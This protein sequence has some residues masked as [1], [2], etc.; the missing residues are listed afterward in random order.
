MKRFFIVLLLSVM[1]CFCDRTLRLDD[2]TIAIVGNHVITFDAYK[3]RYLDFLYL[4]L[5]KDN[6]VTRRQIAQNM[7]NEILLK[8]YDDNSALESNAPYQ[9]DRL[10]SANQMLL[11]FLKDQEV[12]AKIEVGEA[13]IR[14]AFQYSNEQIAA[15]HLYAT[16]EEEALRLYNALQEGADFEQLAYDVFTDSTL[17]NN[18]G[19]IGY[20]SWGDM[21]PSFEETAFGLAVGEISKPV[22]TARGYS[23]IKLEDRIPHPLLTETE[24]QNKRSHFERL[25]RISRKKKY[26][27]Q[28]LAR[29]FDEKNLIFFDT[30][31]DVLWEY[32]RPMGQ[33]SEKLADM[34]T[35]VLR[36]NDKR[37]SV[38]DLIHKTS[39]VPDYHLNQIHSKSALKTLLKG[40]LIQEKLLEHAYSLGYDRHPEVVKA[41]QNADNNLFIKY[42]R[43]AIA[44]KAEIPDS[45]LRA[46]YREHIDDFSKPPLINVHEMLLDNQQQ[47]LR[48]KGQLLSGSNFADL[49]RQHSLRPR[50]AARGGEMGLSAIGQF[51]SL[52][53]RLWDAPLNQII[54]PIEIQGL[55]G[56]FKVTEKIDAQP[57]E[58]KEVISAVARQYKKDHEASLVF[59]YLVGLNKKVDIQVNEELIRWFYIDDPIFN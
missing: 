40:L 21:D 36:Y 46:Y 14:R 42:K 5:M 44:E 49:A 6:W 1:I 8:Y 52:A 19:F 24:Y 12:Y 26:E 28:F 9:K 18:G 51:G 38:S 29:F 55:W 41:T 43:C 54:G 48:I 59:N 30:G 13:E 47:A 2:H 37:Y 33:Q 27:N 17:K 4:S 10:W 20:F 32:L 15:R 22:K 58:Y 35:E 7:I 25:L 53:D 39:Q 56:I 16:T 50:S 45:L 57:R 3:E 31:L 11:G 23:I 34:K